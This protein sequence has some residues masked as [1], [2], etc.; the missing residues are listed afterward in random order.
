[1]ATPS[2]SGAKRAHYY[3]HPVPADPTAGM[4]RTRARRT[5]GR[6]AGLPGRDADT[7]I[8]FPLQ[9]SGSILLRTDRTEGR[10]SLVSV[11]SETAGRSDR[12]EVAVASP[13]RS[14]RTRR[15]VDL[16]TAFVALA[17]VVGTFLVF[18]QPPGQGLDETVH[19]NRVWSLAQG[20]LIAPVHRGSPGDHIPQCV[21]DYVGRFSAQSTKRSSFDFS[22][23]F[24]SPTH[25][26]A[27]APFTGVGTAA[28]NSP[29]SYLPSIVAVGV[30]RGVGAPIPVIFFGGRLAGLLGFIVLFWLAM[31]LTPVG[32]QVF[33]VLG[34]LPAT[35]VLASSYSADPMTISLAAL[36]AALTLRCCLCVDAS[37]RTAGLLF[38]ALVGLG[39]TKPTLFVFAPLLFLVP[40]RVLGPLRWPW[41]VRT[42]AT[43]VVMAIAG[44]WYLP[45]RNVARAPVPIYGLNSHTQTQL[46]V[47]HPASY[48]AVLEHT[49]FLGSG[50]IRWIP[51]F[52]F[53]TGYVRADSNYAPIGI[54]IIGTI[55][56]FFAAQ[57]QFGAKRQARP[58]VLAWLPVPLFLVGAVLVETTLFVYGTPVGLQFTQAQGRYFIP[59]AFLLLVTIGVLRKPVVKLRSD[60]WIAVGVIVMLI[61]LILKIFVHDYSL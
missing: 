20:D 15:R 58:W 1:M 34:L 44:L 29:V 25:C 14:G 49:L 38:L 47:Q 35:L 4:E 36:S 22:D 23:Y 52:F 33:F 5:D 24:R 37:L 31:K 57:L 59:L 16:P 13:G 55:T 28:A 3:V 51:G 50:Q 43:L 45:V 60:R 7:S 32:S 56:L 21:V 39:L 53:S 26:S 54:V 10:S 11:E 19:F 6:R 8:G 12:S 18:A 61:W 46:I 30:L 17:F 2:Q 27:T 48:L 40:G 9:W 42:A 41:L